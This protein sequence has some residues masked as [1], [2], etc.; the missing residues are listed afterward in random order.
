MKTRLVFLV[1]LYLC[2][3]GYLA[4]SAPQLPDRFATHFDGS[5]QPDGWMN[6]SSYVLTTLAFGLAFPLFPV[7][8]IFATRFLP[9]GAIH[10]PHGDYWLAPERRAETF[11]YFFRHSLW[12]AC[13]A[14]GLVIGIHFS[15]IQVNKQL[16]AHLSMLMAWGMPGCF[17]VGVAIWVVA[18]IRHFGRAA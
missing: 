5:G 18:M 12:F 16:P 2:F 10:L 15:T 7:A 17:L 3:L 11:A 9:N 6:R 13:M 1:L 8:L 4:V 14:I